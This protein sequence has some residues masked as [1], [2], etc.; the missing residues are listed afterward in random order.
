MYVLKNFFCCYGNQFWSVKCKIYKMVNLKV[1]LSQKC[2][3]WHNDCT[4]QLSRF[5]TSK[6]QFLH[7]L[8]GLNDTNSN[9]VFVF[10]KFSILLPFIC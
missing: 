8:T 7:D 2:F 4:Y 10:A 1:G 3:I 5:F 9:Q 6:A